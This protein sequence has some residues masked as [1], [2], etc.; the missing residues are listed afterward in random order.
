MTQTR[1][2]LDAQGMSDEEL[3][4]MSDFLA[5]QVDTMDDE[6]VAYGAYAASAVPNERQF[7]LSTLPAR[8][9]LSYRKRLVSWF[10]Y[11]LMKRAK[12]GG[13]GTGIK[14]IEQGLA[15][16]T[17]RIPDAIINSQMIRVSDFVPENE[18]LDPD[19]MNPVGERIFRAIRQEAEQAGVF[20]PQ[21]ISVN[22]PIGF[23][24]EQ[25]VDTGNWYVPNNTQTFY[26]K[27]KLRDMGFRW[28]PKG[29]VWEVAHLT[30][31]IRREFGLAQSDTTTNMR[32]WFEKWLPANINR[33]T[34]IF[35]DYARGK[36]SSYELVFSVKNRSV[37]V[38]FQR[39]VNTAAQAVE[40]LRYRYI[41]KHGRE[42]WLEVMDR[43]IDLVR[44]NTPNQIH[45]LI[46]RINNLQHSN[47]LFM[48]HFPPDVRVWYDAFLNAKYHTPTVDELAKQ[49]PD[50]DLRGLLVEVAKT[51]RRPVDW[52][53]APTPEYHAMKKELQEV[54][55]QI[56]WRARGYPAYKGTKQIDRFSD[57]VQDRLEVLRAL[58]TQREHILS[59]DVTTKEQ[60]ASVVEQ[61][62]DWSVD[63]GRAVDALRDAL[64]AQRQ[65]ELED[66]NHAAAWDAVNFPE[67]FVAKFP[68][69]V[70]GASSSEL[71][72]F[73]ARYASL[74]FAPRRR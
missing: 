61:A 31:D 57:E 63:H 45:R 73:V 41:N 23:T 59:T 18:Y 69:A 53:Y 56:N 36:Q 26:I 48:E 70:P 39:K 13:G 7:I 55:T 17:N 65:R 5:S 74:G 62:R 1:V 8:L 38:S 27:D 19:R 51:R 52:V 24:L 71:A 6:S 3:T 66:P 30:P 34:R 29:R 9:L 25:N 2:A 67:E 35:S 16:F 37:S 20:V 49:I 28:N 54:G 33:F 68:Y 44:A 4:A 12:A 60:E 14:K 11:A 50:R 21:L 22:P 15:D 46:D 64:E 40:E 32:Q 58:D 10:E 42:P 47:G 43:F 72:Q